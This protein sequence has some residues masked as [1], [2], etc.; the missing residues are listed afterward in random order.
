MRT[1]MKRSVP[2][3]LECIGL[4]A[5]QT[6]VKKAINRENNRLNSTNLINRLIQINWEYLDFHKLP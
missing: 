2:L 3:C 6:R 5:I 4:K 1:E